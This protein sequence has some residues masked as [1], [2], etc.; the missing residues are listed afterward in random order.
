MQDLAEIPGLK[1]FIYIRK[2]IED[3]VL[4]DISKQPTI[5]FDEAELKKGLANAFLAFLIPETLPQGP[6]SQR[7]AELLYIIHRHVEPV[8]RGRVNH[9]PGTA[10]E[11]IMLGSSWSPQGE[12][13][14]HGVQ[15]YASIMRKP[16]WLFPKEKLTFPENFNPTK[17]YMRQLGD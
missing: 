12:Q 3:A 8:K 14:D 4:Q 16:N 2:A 13:S 1:I 15:P 9:I 11:F 17:E 10:G 6:V 5:V 7:I